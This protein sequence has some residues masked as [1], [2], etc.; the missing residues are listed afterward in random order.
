M[1]A[2]NGDTNPAPSSRAARL[3]VIRNAVI[4]YNPASG[5]RRHMRARQVE[6]ARRA[7]KEC[8]IHA[9]LCPT[10]ARGSAT[11][12]ARAAVTAGAQLVVASGGDGTVNEV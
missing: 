1:A 6:E 3:G 8:F 4:I 9:E 7:L 11:E 2:A 5:R 12:Q 10:T